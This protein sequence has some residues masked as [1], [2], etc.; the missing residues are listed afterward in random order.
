LSKESVLKDLA[1]AVKYE[2]L[3]FYKPYGHPD[4]LKGDWSLKPWQ[5]DFHQAGLDHRERMLMA[6]NRV[7]KTNSAGAE[8]S[9]HMTGLYPNWWKGKRFN[10]PIL[11][12]TG[13]P[14]NETSRDIIQ[15]SLL[16]GTTKDSLGTGWIPRHCFSGK[17]KNKQAGIS[18]VVDVFKVKHFTNGVYNGD[19]TCVLKTYEQGWRKWQGT[20]PHV[21]WM[22][23]EPEDNEVQG[24]IYPEALTRLLTSNGIL[25]V[26]FT[27]LLGVTRLVEHFQ[28]GGKSIYLDTATWEDAPH[29]NKKAREELKGSYPDHEIESRTS[30]VPMMGEGRVFTTPESEIKV[31]IKKL[32]PRGIPHYFAKIKGIDFGIDHPCATV[33]ICWDRDKDI[34]YI[35]RAKKAKGLSSEEH[36]QLINKVNPWVPVSWPHDGTNREKSNGQRLKDIY[37]NHGVKLLSQSARYKNEKGG[38]QPVEPILLEMQERLRNGGLKVDESCTDFFD[39][40]RNYHRKDGKLTK[41]R[42]DALKAFMYALMMK[43]YATTIVGQQQRPPPSKAMVSM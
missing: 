40:Y 30:G 32:F 5:F 38:A 7:G 14:T 36:S 41:V 35:T 4:T 24:R 15:K 8:A 33:D 18:D 1:K 28:K 11:L 37:V 19:S 17:P 26:T 23:E 22:D 21:V 12:W 27:P 16:G 20:E 2:K 10:H 13:S 9:Y 42:D 31:N 43:R 3:R 6:A 39:E 25:M 34:I 29:L